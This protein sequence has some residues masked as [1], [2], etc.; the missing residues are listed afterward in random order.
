MTVETI[1]EG[2]YCKYIRGPYYKLPEVPDKLA[3][4]L[5]IER[6]PRF[7]GNE[8]DFFDWASQVNGFIASF[9]PYFGRDEFRELTISK[10]PGRYKTY[11]RSL[12]DSIEH[13]YNLFDILGKIIVP[14][15]P[16]SGIRN[17]LSTTAINLFDIDV[18]AIRDYLEKHRILCQMNGWSD[19]ES[20]RDLFNT[21][22]SPI[23]G[24]ILDLWSRKVPYQQA[25]DAAERLVRTVGAKAK[26]ELQSD[27]SIDLKNVDRTSIMAII[28]KL[29]DVWVKK[30]GEDV[31]FTEFEP[32]NPDGPY[33]ED[34]LYEA[35]IQRGTSMATKKA[36]DAILEAKSAERKP[37]P[38][39]MPSKQGTSSKPPLQNVTTGGR[40]DP[41]ATAN[42]ISRKKT[43]VLDL[44]N[45]LLET[46]SEFLPL[47]TFLN[48]QITCKAFREVLG[49]RLW[50]TIYIAD[51]FEVKKVDLLPYERTCSPLTVLHPACCH[52]RCIKITD[53]NVESFI[54][55]VKQSEKKNQEGDQVLW[56]LAQV[57][58]IVFMLENNCRWREAGRNPR[59]EISDSVGFLK[60]IERIL[61]R[62]CPHITEVNLQDLVPTEQSIKFFQRFHEKYPN[63]IFNAECYVWPPGK[64]ARV[65]YNE[66]VKLENLRFLM[67]WLPAENINQLIKENELP[68]G[69][70]SFCI[71]SFQDMVISP[72]D[73]KKFF[74]KTTTLR[75]LYLS[76]QMD[77]TPYSLEWVPTTVEHLSTHNGRE[78][79]KKVTS[80]RGEFEFMQAM[81]IKLC[82]ETATIF[83]KYTFPNLR[84]LNLA[85]AEVGTLSWKR[86]HINIFA[87]CP[88][89]KEFVCIGADLVNWVDQPVPSIESLITMGGVLNMD[90]DL[91]P[92]RSVETLRK[93]TNLRS[94]LVNIYG[95]Y[96]ES[97]NHLEHTKF[98]VNSCSQLKQFFYNSDRSFNSSGYYTQNHQEEYNAGFGGFPMD[99][100]SY[101][102]EIR[103]VRR[104]LA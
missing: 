92:L 39:K 11:L 35:I 32:F 70:T 17:D 41:A 26:S 69:I 96:G 47:R 6:I 9:S 73:L 62:H 33:D 97:F 61:M 103:K 8:E 63:A 40:L 10:L 85:Y 53:S 24:A 56:G 36:R 77:I 15:G 93:L 82:N 79:G 54:K 66:V 57:Q 2:E 48:L 49:K 3:A 94:I 13:Y 27:N 55:T 67:I 25:L 75:N 34:R 21:L 65:L 83:D 86:K 5:P 19:E 30:Y 81:E 60:V 1:R 14:N 64:E 89:L 104:V 52:R 90:L 12:A 91:D 76:Y 16:A 28:G 87:S 31:R 23:S 45:E 50:R 4:S 22:S 74:S 51:T 46:V 99:L 80:H 95:H 78:D 102:V 18:T 88:N 38:K 42:S 84:Y 101:E 72:K 98:V 59:D 37:C 68:D 7:T 20:T 29:C 100:K 44:P 58:R 43:N 71:A